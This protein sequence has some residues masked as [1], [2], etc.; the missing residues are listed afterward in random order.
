ML[1]GLS[2]TIEVGLELR[3]EGNDVGFWRLEPDR[4]IG[5]KATWRE[6]KDWAA[7]NVVEATA[8]IA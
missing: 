7:V 1:V 4:F 6:S 5:V 3:F 2:V 8:F